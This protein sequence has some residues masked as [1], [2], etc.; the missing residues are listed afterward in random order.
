MIEVFVAIMVIVCIAYFGMA[1]WTSVLFS[2]VRKK[3]GNQVVFSI[4]K[5][6]PYMRQLRT[7]ANPNT[8]P[9]QANRDEQRKAVINW[10]AFVGE[11]AERKP[12]WN[13]E[14]LGRAISGYNQFTQYAR[15][16]FVASESNKVEGDPIQI[17]YTVPID[18]SKMGLYRLR[19]DDTLVQIFPSGNLSPGDDEAIID[20]TDPVPG[21][22][23]YFIGPDPVYD[24]LVGADQIAV[25]CANWRPNN[26][27]GVA[28]S[29]TTVVSAP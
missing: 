5:G 15:K 17:T 9:Q 3:L 7:P 25:C 11:D 22:Y 27:T 20:E 12:I 21:T 8:L 10:Q 18:I 16:I 6:R 29:A 23:R 13:I 26:G 28:D 14:G 4:W 2:D 1:K 19:S 24:G